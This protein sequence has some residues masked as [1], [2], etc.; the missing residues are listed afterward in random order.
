MFS[1]PQFLKTS[2]PENIVSLSCFLKDE[3]ALFDCWLNQETL[4]PEGD[5][6]EL[7]LESISNNIAH[8]CSSGKQILFLY[9]CFLRG[10]K[11]ESI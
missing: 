2:K 7:I 8:I 1:Q 9:E 6:F 3:Q 5:Q 4:F 11:P 10:G